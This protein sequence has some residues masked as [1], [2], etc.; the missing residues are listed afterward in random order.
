MKTIGVVDAVRADMTLLP[1]STQAET[2][3]HLARL[4]I[5][6]E[7]PWILQEYVDGAEYCT[8]SLIVN[9]R[10]RA[11]VACPSAELLM[12]YK[13]LPLEDNL[14][15]AMLAFTATV[16]RTGGSNF[17]GHVSFDFMVP[18]PAFEVRKAPENLTLDQLTKYIRIYPIECNPR[19]HTAVALFNGTASLADAYLSILPRERKGKRRPETS[20]IVV[21]AHMDR[22]YWIGHDL[23]T[24]LILPTISFLLFRINSAELLLGYKELLVH[25]STWKDGT[26]EFW[27][28]LPFWFLYQV[29][30]PGKSLSHR[31]T[32]SCLPVA[33]RPP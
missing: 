19:A 1:K 6:D 9:G 16:A 5:S 12:H 27:D 28:P 21:P 30:W 25:L 26:F 15:K 29:Y 20:D 4:P 2:S 22:Y 7:V 13:A 18:K 33:R 8:H 11:F 32:L 3:H 23:L 10:V 31:L 24:L 14:T 17:S